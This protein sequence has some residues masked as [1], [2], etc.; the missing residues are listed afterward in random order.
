MGHFLGLGGA[1]RLTWSK[2][3]AL[4]SAGLSVLFLVVYNACNHLTALRSDVPVWM[5]SWEARI[6][7][8]PLMI[9]PYMS[10][11]LFFVAAPFLFRDQVGLRTFRQRIVASI[12]VAGV[13]YLLFPL[14]LGFDRPHAEG[15]LGAIFNP[16]VAL[17]QPHNLLPSLH[18][19]LRTI[20]ADVYARHTKGIWR[21][22]S[23]VWF[24]LIGFSTV[25]THQHQVVDVIGGFMLAAAVFHCYRDEPLA[26]PVRPNRRV[27]FY[28]GVA[29]TGL[30]VLSWIWRPQGSILLWPAFSLGLLWAANLWLGPGVFRKQAGKLPLLT[31][32]VLAPVL[33]GQQL[34]LL[35]Y[36]RQC[37]A[38]D[39]VAEN[40]WIGRVL[41]SI[42]ARQAIAE[43]VVAV[44]DLTGEFAEAEP[45]RALPYLNLPVLD[46]TAPSPEQVATAL[47]F[48][49]QHRSQGAV[50]IHCKIGYSRSVAI[51]GAWLLAQGLATT[52]EQAVGQI[53]AA[54]PAI[55]VR[56]EI[57]HLL[58]EVETA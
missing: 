31:R 7:F 24:S 57:W 12:L 41:T 53:R 22:A 26:L 52:A 4:T 39:R 47:R 8:V 34:S 1:P 25:L 58:R 20:L 14:R 46:L 43:G 29:A 44:V 32:A 5:F 37:R 15:W 16:F 38:W 18:I 48:I 10:I 55:V 3:A 6:P 9:V 35:W 11:D 17:D 28:Y 27:A 45:F 50:Y 42:E 51:A 40:V 36:A 13:C 33:W 19:T 2:R 30:V 21:V 49:N 23:H 56:P 54:R